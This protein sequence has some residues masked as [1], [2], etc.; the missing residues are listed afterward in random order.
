MKKILFILILLSITIFSGCDDTDINFDPTS[1]GWELWGTGIVSDLKI[2]SRGSASR[3]FTI[4][5]LGGQEIKT[6]RIFKNFNE[7]Q[8]GMKGSIYKLETFTHTYFL[9][10][11]EKSITQKS[12]S[13]PTKTV[14]E[15]TKKEIKQ[16]EIETNTPLKKI[17][18]YEWQTALMPP[19]TNQTVLVK[20]KN[21]IVTTAY[22]TNKGEWKAEVDKIKMSRGMALENILEWKF[23]NLE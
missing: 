18:V 8:K 6:N 12:K 10:E 5:F 4:I 1:P 15:E 11:E 20:F 2:E 9:W 17:I 14:N 7:I 19:P 23:L 16:I 21:G 22:Y 13:A 3:T